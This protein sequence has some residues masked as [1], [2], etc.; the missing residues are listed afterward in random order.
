MR[1]LAGEIVLKWG[2]QVPDHRDAP[3]PAQEPLPGPA[4]HVGHV[5]VVHGEAEDPVGR[6]I[7]ITS[8]S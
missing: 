4:A 3:G 6:D 8:Q 7:K 5:C 1:L 2:K